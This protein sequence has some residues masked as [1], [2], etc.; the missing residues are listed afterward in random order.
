MVAT[1]PII[2]DAPLAFDPLA[3]AFDAAKPRTIL[4]YL[5][6]ARIIPARA[7]SA[8]REATEERVALVGT[9]RKDGSAQDSMRASNRTAAAPSVVLSPDETRSFLRVVGRDLTAW[10]E[11]AA[12]MPGSSFLTLTFGSAGVDLSDDELLAILA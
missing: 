2:D 4:G 6:S 9:V 11:G 7:A 8:K 12:H 10:V 5:G 3:R 1:T